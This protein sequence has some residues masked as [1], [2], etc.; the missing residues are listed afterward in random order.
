L[1][2]KGPPL[3]AGFFFIH[4]TTG[5]YTKKPSLEEADHSIFRDRPTII[6]IPLTI[7]RLFYYDMTM[8]QDK[9]NRDMVIIPGAFPLPG[10]HGL[11]IAGLVVAGFPSPA[12]EELR[13]IISF[14]DY[15]IPRPQASF[16]LRVSGNSMT[17][18]GIMPGDLVI[19]EKGRMPK[20]GNIV[21]A[22]VDGDWAMRFFRKEKGQVVLEAANAD[23]T[24]IHPK[25]ELR[26]IG[27]VTACV[28]K[29]AL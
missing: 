1:L 6:K 22:E 20:H 27:I 8:D 23:C 12:E 24:P 21:I 16:L 29:Y 2:N 10:Q 28:R 25:M 15:L 14:D 17:A 26:L 7:E 18:A 13:D 19:V 5:K 3:Q 9:I 4:R 11:Q